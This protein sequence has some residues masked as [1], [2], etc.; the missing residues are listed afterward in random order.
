MLPTELALFRAHGGDSVSVQVDSN[1]LGQMP[2]HI[3]TADNEKIMQYLHDLGAGHMP[4]R[5]MKLMLVGQEVCV[6][7]C[8]HLCVHM[9]LYACVCIIALLQRIYLCLL[10]TQN[11][12]KTTLMKGLREGASMRNKMM[13]MI[14]GKG[15]RQ[16]TEGIDIEEWLPEGGNGLT[17]SAWDFGGQE[18][19]AR[20]AFTYA[21]HSHTHH[22]GSDACPTHKRAFA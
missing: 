15:V 12:G 11:V 1:P 3:A 22:K 19:R 21:H 9:Y 8:A 10:C 6:R 4:C 7:A 14:T 5:R 20:R 18:V 2:P 17:L 16:S 13:S